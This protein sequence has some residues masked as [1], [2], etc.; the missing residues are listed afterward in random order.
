MDDLIV[1]TIIRIVTPFIYLYGVYIIL[2]AS[3]SPGGSFAGGAIM[4]SALVLYT[5][6]FGL[7]KAEK[8]VPNRIF[9][10]QREVLLCFLFM[11]F[12]T[13][14]MGYD[15]LKLREAG[16]YALEMG[17]VVKVDLLNLVNIGIAM[18]VAVTLISLFHVFIKEDY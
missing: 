5:I 11:G 12:V 17:Q 9:K 13:I 10:W 4:G 8:K 1:K 2:N 7:E 14:F 18:K 3:V 16:A 6:A 15:V